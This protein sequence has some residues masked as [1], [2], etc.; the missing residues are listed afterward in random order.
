MLIAVL[1]ICVGVCLTAGDDSGFAGVIGAITG[2]YSA[3]RIA[4]D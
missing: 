3:C 1:A 4:A 2:L